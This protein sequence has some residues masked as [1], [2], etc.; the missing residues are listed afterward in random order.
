MGLREAFAAILQ[1]VRSRRELSQHD[2]AG[3]VTQSHVSQLESLKTSAT[4]DTSQELARALSLHPISFL[5]LVHA[6]HDRKSA[7]DVLELAMQELE[8]MSLLDAPLP[9]APEQLRHPQIESAERAWKDVQALK[10]LGKTQSEIVTL[11]GLPR[12][13]VGRHWHKNP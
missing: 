12:S 9:Q 13:T 10:A 1:L 7:R 6:A 5:A 4:L 3:A 11:L 8:A 2:V